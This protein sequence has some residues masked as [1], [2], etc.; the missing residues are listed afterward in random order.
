MLD[1]DSSAS[2]KAT[3]VE[4][5]NIKAEIIIPGKISRDWLVGAKYDI[6]Y[7]DGDNETAVEA[8]AHPAGYQDRRWP[9]RRKTATHPSSRCS[10]SIRSDRLGSRVDGVEGAIVALDMQEA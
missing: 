10:G 4:L 6:A 1:H 3:A 9:S 2:V 8:H 7:D 5:K